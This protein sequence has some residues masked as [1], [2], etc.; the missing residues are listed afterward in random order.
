MGKFLS[1][2]SWVLAFV[3]FQGFSHNNLI[4]KSPFLPAKTISVQPMNI[5]PN[6]NRGKADV[7]FIFSGVASIG[8]VYHFSL[9][10]KRSGKSVWLEQ[11]EVFNNFMI[12]SY[13]PH[14]RRVSYQWGSS[15]G[16]IELNNSGESLQISL[17]SVISNDPKINRVEIY[18]SEDDHMRISANSSSTRKVVFNRQLTRKDDNNEKS[19]FYRSPDISRSGLSQSFAANV[20]S[21]PNLSSRDT[22][23]DLAVSGN[24]VDN[25]A[26][27]S[28]RAFMRGANRV[29]NPGGRLPE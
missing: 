20:P 5:Q 10:D 7:S 13:N 1:L 19:I 21:L 11:G 6:Q 2:L 28:D 4:V 16:S 3:P 8:G 27:R 9:R 29:N 15:V 23:T 22:P 12:T 25:G 14:A 18:E 26:V 17:P 24:A